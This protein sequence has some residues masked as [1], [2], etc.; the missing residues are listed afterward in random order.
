MNIEKTRSQGDSFTSAR[1]DSEAEPQS[2]KRGEH[3]DV[4]N[5]HALPDE[6]V[7]KRSRRIKCQHEEG[8]FACVGPGSEPPG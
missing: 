8:A 4:E 6:R 3:E 5:W 1:Y 7:A 2:K